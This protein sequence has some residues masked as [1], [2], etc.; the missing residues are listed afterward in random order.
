V[1]VLALGTA[2]SGASRQAADRQNVVA[3]MHAQ[4]GDIE[5][6]RHSVIRGDLDGLVEP[7]RALAESRP[8]AG[9]PPQ[10]ER[11]YQELRTLAGQAASTTS[12]EKAGAVTAGMMNTCGRCHAEAGAKVALTPPE[13]P[14][15]D[16]AEAPGMRDHNWAA[17]MMALGLL[18]PADDLWERGARALSA[19]PLK[20]AVA[21]L[22][23]TTSSQIAAREKQLHELATRA[24]QT[25]A[26]A[27][28]SAVYGEVLA[29][30]GGCHD[31]S[32]RVLG[33]GLPR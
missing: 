27:G 6:L 31:L 8:L 16:R 17:E 21:D 4:L 24:G 12:L 2:P 19:M 28:R 23:Q 18:G 22:D 25:A 29:T 7:A 11:F 5:A 30:C 20:P 9:L 26:G 1:L 15:T 3:L 10:A 32:G 13:R 33:T 14:A